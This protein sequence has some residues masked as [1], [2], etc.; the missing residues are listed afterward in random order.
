MPLTLFRIV[1]LQEIIEQIERTKVQI[2]LIGK[3][4][5]VSVVAHRFL[6]RTIQSLDDIRFNIKCNLND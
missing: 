3:R 2:E 1:K 5:D 4:N 6:L